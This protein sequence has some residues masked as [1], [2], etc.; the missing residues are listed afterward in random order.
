MRSS[1]PQPREPPAGGQTRQRD[2]HNW[3]MSSSQP[4]FAPPPDPASGG[5]AVPASA[6]G[7]PPIWRH[8]GGAPVAC[9]EKIKV[10]NENYAELRQMTQDAFEDALL[11]GC[12]EM[13]VRAVLRELVDRLT[14]PY[15][16][17]VDPEC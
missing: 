13:Q 4:H 7:T 10:L 9:V 14:N 2:G 12:S 8:D 15:P 17:K 16:G 11:L 5:P 6:T 1:L 3:G